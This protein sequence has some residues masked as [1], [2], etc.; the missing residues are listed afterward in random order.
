M[1]KD[2]RLKL[3]GFLWWGEWGI[4]MEF[5]DPRGGRELCSALGGREVVSGVG[6]FLSVEVAEYHPGSNCVREFFLERL[7]GLRQ[8]LP[9]YQFPHCHPLL[10]TTLPGNPREAFFRLVQESHDAP[11]SESRGCSLIGLQAPWVAGEAVKS[12]PGN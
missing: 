4:L 9:R 6:W 8:N 1:K 12:G 3:T 7:S 5:A 10:L 11:T 2:S